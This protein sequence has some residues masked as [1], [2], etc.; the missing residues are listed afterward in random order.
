MAKTSLPS[1]VMY[2]IGAMLLI[3]SAGALFNE[4]N[5]P[6]RE[7]MVGSLVCFLLGGSLLSLGYFINGKI[8]RMKEARAARELA[9]ML[10]KNDRKPSSREGKKERGVLLLVGLALLLVAMWMGIRIYAWILSW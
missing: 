9:E 3:V 10:K 4:N 2:Y 7:A 5:L 6:R 8:N 1:A